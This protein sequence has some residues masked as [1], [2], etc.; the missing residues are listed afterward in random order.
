MVVKWWEKNPCFGWEA[1]ICK[2]LERVIIYNGGMSF[3][4]SAL[5]GAVITYLSVR[6]RGCVKWRCILHLDRS[7][8]LDQDKRSKFL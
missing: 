5:L 1:G 2:L 8:G 7:I 4:H 3:H 6:S